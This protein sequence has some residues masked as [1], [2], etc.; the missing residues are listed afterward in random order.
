MPRGKK[1]AARKRQ[2]KGEAVYYLLYEPTEHF[3]CGPCTL[4]GCV[5]E[6][7]MEL[8]ADPDLKASEYVIMKASHKLEEES[9]TV[10][11]SAKELKQKKDGN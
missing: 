3:V 5:A 6:A 7:E 1:K 2:P 9:V 10:R 8:E 11:L 4:E